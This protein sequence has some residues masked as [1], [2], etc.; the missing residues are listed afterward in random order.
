[1]RFLLKLAFLIGLALFFLAPKHEDGTGTP[2]DLNAASL[3]FGV[4]QAVADLGGF[5]E[6]APLACESGR[7]AAVFAGERIAEGMAFVYGL[8]TGAQPSVPV[9]GPVDQPETIRPTRPSEHPA[10][11]A[12]AP[13]PY[14]P[15][16]HGA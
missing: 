9:P 14:L 16:V 1:M 15:P 7:N 10:N 12:P 11:G 5:C 13:R 8:A 4:Q 2:S 6:R 3:I